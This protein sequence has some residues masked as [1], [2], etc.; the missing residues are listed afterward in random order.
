MLGSA[1][2]RHPFAAV[3]RVSTVVEARTVGRSVRPL[4][5]PRTASILFL[6][7]CECFRSGEIKCQIG[8]I[9]RA[10]YSDNN[11]KNDP[12]SSR[13]HRRVPLSSHEVL[14]VVMTVFLRRQ[15]V[16]QHRI[17]SRSRY[18][19]CFDCLLHGNVHMCG[20]RAIED[21]TIAIIRAPCQF[22]KYLVGFQSKIHDREYPN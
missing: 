13:H 11:C 8:R 9:V 17:C 22:H 5:E 12:L 7:R 15:I 4:T 18:I 6:F 20:L 2:V 10:S 1:Q 3:E 19:S 16:L 14:I 21:W